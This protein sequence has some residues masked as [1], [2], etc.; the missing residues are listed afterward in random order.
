MVNPKGVSHLETYRFLNFIIW[1]TKITKV[2]IR[3][4]SQNG[5]EEIVHTNMKILGYV[6][7]H[8]HHLDSP[9]L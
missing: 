2:I 8:V 7:P 3:L 4:P 5:E 9:P 1:N 6:S